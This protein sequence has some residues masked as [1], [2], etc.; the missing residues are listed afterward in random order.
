MIVEFFRGHIVT[1]PDFV[2]CNPTT[3]YVGWPGSNARHGAG[4]GAGVSST[5]SLPAFLYVSSRNSLCG[6]GVGVSV[7]VGDGSGEVGNG[8]SS[9]ETRAP[10]AN[11][12]NAN[13]ASAQRVRTFILVRFLIGRSSCVTISLSLPAS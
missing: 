2:N 5:V 12:P 10:T 9:D 13:S 4:T 1:P 8:D 3:F 6:V 11:G 7:A